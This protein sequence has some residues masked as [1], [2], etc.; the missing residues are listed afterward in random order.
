MADQA[1]SGTPATVFAGRRDRVDSG[2]PREQRFEEVELERV[3]RV[4]LRLFR[5]LV[6]LHEHAVD[7]GSDAG[8]GHRL[9][10]LGL[11]GGDAVAGARQLQAVGH[12]VDHGISEAAQHRQR[13]HVHDEVVVAERGAALGQDHAIV[14]GRR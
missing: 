6:H 10:E 2:Q 11:A 3:L 13:P 5:P 1:R 4:A 14:A 9:D 7:A 8:A 12:V